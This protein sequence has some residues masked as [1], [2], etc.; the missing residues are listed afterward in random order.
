MSIKGRGQISNVRY[1]RML[2]KAKHVEMEK[3]EKTL[4]MGNH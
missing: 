1:Q 3:S 2:P 4:E